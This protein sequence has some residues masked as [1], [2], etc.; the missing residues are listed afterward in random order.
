MHQYGFLYYGKHA[1][2]MGDTDKGGSSVCL[3]NL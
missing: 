2:V 3:V 1:M